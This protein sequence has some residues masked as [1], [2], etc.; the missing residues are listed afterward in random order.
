MTIYRRRHKEDSDWQGRFVLAL[1]LGPIGICSAAPAVPW[2][3]YVLPGN[4]DGLLASV[5]LM[6]LG[7]PPCPIRQRSRDQRLPSSQLG[8]SEVS[9]NL[10]MADRGGGIINT[11]I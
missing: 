1:F 7:V 9:H 10:I 8:L 4:E 3:M 5:S 2:G 11:S 6:R